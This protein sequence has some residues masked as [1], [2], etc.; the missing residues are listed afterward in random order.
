MSLRLSAFTE[1]ALA[2]LP[3]PPARVLEVGCGSGEVAV[4]LSRAGHDVTAIDPK[5]P[6]GELFRRTTLEEFD[7]G[8]FDG[9]VASVSLHHVADVQRAFD[10]LEALLRAD[11]VLVLEEFA[12]ERL[13]GATA[14]WYFEERRARATADDDLPDD[15]DTWLRR[16]REAHDEIHPFADLQRELEARFVERHFVRTPYLYDYRLDDSL[17]PVERALIDSGAIEAVGVRYV[18]ELRG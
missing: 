10:K 18:G 1:F 8:V 3:A 4:A 2:H 17:E 15:V 11:G 14:Q 16:W 9:V 12:S 6:D 7:G 13:A 5:A